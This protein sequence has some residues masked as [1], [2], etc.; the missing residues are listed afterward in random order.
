MEDK[1]KDI[2]K[3]IVSPMYRIIMGTISLLSGV[4]MGITSGFSFY[5]P[6]SGAIWAL[7]TLGSTLIGLGISKE[8]KHR[9]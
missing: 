9:G 1:K 8:L 3:D 4:G 6:E 2:K 7:I 5:N